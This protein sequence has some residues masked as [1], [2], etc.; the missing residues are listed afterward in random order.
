VYARDDGV[1][2]V[3]RE[4]VGIA[5][6]CSMGRLRWR[7]MDE[8]RQMRCV[9]CGDEILRERT[10]LG[11]TYCTKRACVRANATGLLVAEIAQHK[12]NAEY[13]I[14]RGEAGQKALRDMREGNYRRDP[15]VV[16]RERQH[17]RFDVPKAEFRKPTVKKYPPNRIKFVQALQSQGFTVEEIL[18]KGAY[19]G[20][21]RS[22]VVRYMTARRGSTLR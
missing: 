7:A 2:T 6:R 1:V 12:T 10:E 3:E 11:F 15:V 13:V 21:T 17:A 14:L 19:M 5:D 8:G 16:K 18:A 9:T 4:L 22:E 20:L